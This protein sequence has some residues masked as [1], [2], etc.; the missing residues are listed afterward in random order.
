[1]DL[2]NGDSLMI[3][4]KDKILFINLLLFLMMIQINKDLLL[5]KNLI[6]FVYL[7]KYPLIYIF[8]HK[9]LQE[10]YLDTWI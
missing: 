2:P 5:Y 3:Y 6:K 7:D 1:M 8:K 4:L 10:L 9:A